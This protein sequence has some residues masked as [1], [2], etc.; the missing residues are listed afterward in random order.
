MRLP[1]S[2]S[3]QHMGSVA[4]F[5]IAGSMVS[6]ALGQQI[7]HA[8]HVPQPAASHQSQ[9]A[10]AL[11]ARIAAPAPQRPAPV[12]QKAPAVSHTQPAVALARTAPA[13]SQGGDRHDDEHH[14][15]DGH[16]GGHGDKHGG[17]GGDGQG[18]GGD[19]GGN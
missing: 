2:V 15:G 18:G 7:G 8:T 6:F 17:G 3:T 11:G 10:G 14:G 16:P 9:A 5:L 1:R 13:A 4:A 19:G 12:A